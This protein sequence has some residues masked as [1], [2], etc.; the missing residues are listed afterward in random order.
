MGLLQERYKTLKEN[1]Y[2]TSKYI[3]YPASSSN[4]LIEESKQQSN[5]VKTYLDKMAF[6]ECDI[7]FLREN[8][9]PNKSL[10]T[11]EVRNNVVVQAKIKY[12]QEP[13]KQQWAFLNRWQAK[14]LS[15]GVN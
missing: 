8:A 11:V 7:Y 14:I 15:K 5:C 13:T 2:K 9:N 1:I 4:E 10:V 3:I 6:A 12:N